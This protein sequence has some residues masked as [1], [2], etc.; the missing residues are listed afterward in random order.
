MY[1]SLNSIIL[2][3]DENQCSRTT[4]LPELPEEEVFQ[5]LG[6]S[7]AFIDIAKGKEEQEKE[8]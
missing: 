7:I 8:N 2:C 5:S 4:S 1:S 6:L 3:N